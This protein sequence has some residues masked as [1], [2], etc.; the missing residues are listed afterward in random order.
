MSLKWGIWFAVDG[1][2]RF[3]AHRD[4][5]RLMA[6]L[7]ARAKLP[8]RFSQGYNPRPIM[9]L[10]CPRPVAVATRCDLLVLS[11]DAPS[12]GGAVDPAILEALAPLAPPGLRFLRAER[13]EGKRLP[14]PARIDYERPVSSQSAGAIG[15]RL[16]ELKTRDSWPVERKSPPARGRRAPA[17]RNLDLKPLVNNVRLE[18]NVLRWSCVP[19][20]DRWARPGEFLALL[21]L[22]DPEDIAAVTR[23]NVEFGS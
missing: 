20:E 17:P 9:S 22:A 18:N 21:G 11:L 6:R 2:L 15:R 8:V 14:R 3:A 10:I 1:D 7:T 13:L 12:E 4:M 19:C 5:M 23:T 16:D